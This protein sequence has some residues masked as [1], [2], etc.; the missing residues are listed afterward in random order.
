MRVRVDVESDPRDPQWDRAP[1]ARRRRTS[2]PRPAPRARTQPCAA[3]VV[4]G[5]EVESAKRSTPSCADTSAIA[6]PPSSCPRARPWNVGFAR[7][8]GFTEARAR[9]DN[10][11][12][13]SL[14]HRAGGTVALDGARARVSDLPP[15]GARCRAGSARTARRRPNTRRARAWCTCG[16]RRRGSTRP[17]NRTSRR[18]AAISQ[19]SRR[20]LPALYE[21]TARPGLSGNSARSFEVRDAERHVHVGTEQRRARRSGA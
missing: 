3:R 8:G 19:R 4:L 2:P 12:P 7:V 11:A 14:R 18:A 21:G 5:E 15:H 9:R 20:P 17:I 16:S 6:K 10:R 13:R 1:G